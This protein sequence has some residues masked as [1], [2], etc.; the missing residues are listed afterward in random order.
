MDFSTAIVQHSGTIVSWC[1]SIVG[2]SI[3][4]IVSNE[5]VRP[6]GKIMKL[7]YLLFLPG[8]FF[9]ALTIQ[10][11]I[12]IGDH[13]IMASLMQKD[14]E[15]SLQILAKMGNEYSKLLSCFNLGL[16]FFSIWIV[17]FLLFYIFHKNEKK[18]L[19]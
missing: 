9:L 18:T 3:L 2:G 7:L 11:G 13:E 10:H 19:S 16:L 6:V 4:V 12:N 8:W 17:A 14:E 15:K 1:L 5:Y